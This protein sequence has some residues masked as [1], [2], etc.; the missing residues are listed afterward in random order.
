MTFNRIEFPFSTEDSELWPE[1][2][3][4]DPYSY[5]FPR[6]ISL[7]IGESERA[8]ALVREFGRLESNWD[9]YGAQPL[10]RAATDNA[11]RFL[12]VLSASNAPTPDLSP[13][14]NGTIALEWQSAVGFAYL[15]IGN[16]RF[17]MVASQIF[18]GKTL[19]DG[20]AEEL[21]FGH[22]SLIKEALFP[23]HTYVTS[24]NQITI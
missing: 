6:R 23:D 19:C 17:S 14:A 1:S 21:G 3:W 9:G 5:V 13:L 22:A 18:G 20:G 10:S 11:T 24:I 16:S 2:I 15:E 7:S 12:G 4:P 8:K